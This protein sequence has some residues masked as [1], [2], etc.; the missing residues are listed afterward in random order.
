MRVLILDGNENQAV[1]AA[2]S[3]GRA[4]YDVSV[5]ASSAWSKAGW[6]RY[7]KT[8]FRYTSPSDDASLFARDVVAEAARAPG[9]L[10]LPMTER[11]TVVVSERRA[12][13]EAVSARYVLPEHAT[14]L[15]AMDKQAMT[16]LA[17]SLG[18]TV[19][20]TSVLGT[21]AEARRFA[22]RAVYPVVLKPRTSEEI[23]RRG[24]PRPTGKP[25]YAR[26][27]PE[28]MTAFEQLQTRA[29]DILA[30][31]YVEGVGVGY[32][33]LAR[34][35]EVRAEFAHRRLRD[36][37]PS[38][39]GSALRES[40]PLDHALK[41]AGRRILESIGWHGVAMVEFRRRDDGTLCFLEVNGRFWNSLA[42]PIHAGVDFPL[43]VARLAED[44]DVTPVTAYRVGVR[45]RWWLGDVR[46]LVS[47]LSGRPAGFTG[48]Y[49]ARLATLGAFL[50]PVAGTHHDNFE[51]TDPLPE[52]GDWLDFAVRRLPAAL[53][54][55]GMHHAPTAP[56][57]PDR[58]VR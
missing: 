50:R 9:T 58:G 12:E 48:R 16:D 2:R 17:A 28:L 52:A 43:L 4:G 36:V 46:H 38:G 24:A 31:E 3:L 45:C 41:V 47:V 6:S 26:S 23:D 56:G 37:R 34:H 35:G 1:A 30:Q 8:Q 49:P 32:F 22:T 20:A 53:H 10:V 33:A 19:P 5:G 39:S 29:G 7:A 57:A 21:A 51:W 18:I 25:L 44:G 15:R 27:A 40:V 55:K 14:L 13:L 54:R 42:L 11:T